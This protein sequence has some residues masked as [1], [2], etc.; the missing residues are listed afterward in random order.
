MSRILIT[1]ASG[2]IG[3]GLLD[4]V[5][6]LFERGDEI[7]LL[8]HERGI[9]IPRSDYLRL[10]KTR[11]LDERTYD[12]V[13]HTAAFTDTNKCKNPVYRERVIEANVALTKKIC[14]IAE[15]LLLFS[16]VN[17]FKG[18]ADSAPYTEKEKVCP[19]DFYGRTKAEAEQIVLDKDKGSIIRLGHVIGV[20]N[21]IID[22]NVVKGIRTGEYWPFWNDVYTQ[23]SYIDDISTAIEKIYKSN[24]KGVYHIG[25]SGRVLSR[26]EIA[27]FV[28]A[29]WKS[30]GW[31][32]CVD[33]FKHESCDRNDFPRRL[34]LN[35]DFTKS[36]LDITFNNSKEAIIKHIDSRYSIEN[37]L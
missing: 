6:S 20:S 22:D 30:K 13:L 15:R 11:D 1:G 34:V 36:E 8:E 27:D 4:K 5:G 37:E 16:T 7:Y 14:N 32:S 29:I 31:P 12:F 25:C 2:R 18:E 19:C 28:L 26:A 9:T 3:K 24:R 10:Y 21:R 33:S 35:C 23:L 17:V